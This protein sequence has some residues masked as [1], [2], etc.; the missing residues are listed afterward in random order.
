MTVKR[1]AAIIE[2]VAADFPPKIWESHTAHFEARWDGTGLVLAVH[3]E[4]DAANAAEIT[5]CVRDGVAD[6]QW[7]VLDLEGVEFM[8]TAGFAALHD[9]DT[10]LVDG[11]SW[12]LVPSAAVSRL[13]RICDPHGTLPSQ[14][15]VAE[16]LAYVRDT[17]VL[18]LLG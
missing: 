6:C 13:L 16:A 9:I 18:R 5:Q 17:R 4:I 1:T 3:G 2:P 15:S 12:A 10:D 7:V 8:G 11:V 14:Q